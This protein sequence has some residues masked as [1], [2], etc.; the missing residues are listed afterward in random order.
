MQNPPP[1][2]RNI[3]NDKL[4]A[5]L[6]RTYLRSCRNTRF[7]FFAI[8]SDDMF[9]EL[10]TCLQPSLFLFHYNEDYTLTSKVFCHYAILQNHCNLCVI[11]KMTHNSSTYF[12]LPIFTLPPPATQWMKKNAKEET[13]SY[14]NSVENWRAHEIQIRFHYCYWF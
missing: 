2:L 9:S 14:S 6:K 4:T 13:I 12:F 1:S 7:L 3:K 10:H 8:V 11:I 5:C